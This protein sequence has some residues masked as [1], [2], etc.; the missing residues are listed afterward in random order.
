MFSKAGKISNT[1]KSH[2]FKIKKKIKKMIKK[3]SKNDYKNT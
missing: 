1:V 3:E 2:L